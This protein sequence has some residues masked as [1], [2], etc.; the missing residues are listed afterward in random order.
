MKRVC[1]DSASN[2]YHDFKNGW[3]SEPGDARAGFGGKVFRF[4]AATAF[5]HSTGKCFDIVDYHSLFD[6]LSEADEI[7]TFNGRTCDL[8]VLESLIG[9]ADMRS[10]WAKPHHDLRGWRGQNSLSGAVG[11]LRPERAQ[12]FASMESARRTTLS[13]KKGYSDF[14]RERL[15]NT[16]RDARFTLDLFRLYLASGDTEFTFQDGIPAVAG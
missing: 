6:L 1:F 12:S 7:I 4:D 5:L 3:L 15:A 13:K 9:E 10:I 14:T 8:I 16:Y 2:Y 11:L